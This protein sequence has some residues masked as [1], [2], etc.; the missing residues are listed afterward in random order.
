MAAFHRYWHGC[1]RMAQPIE[2]VPICEAR[3][4]SSSACMGHLERITPPSVNIILAAGYYHNCPARVS[5]I[6][7]GSPQ[8][9]AKRAQFVLQDNARPRTGGCCSWPGT[10]IQSDAARRRPIRYTPH[11][12]TATR[13]RTGGGGGDLPR[14]SPRSRRRR[15]PC[16][17]RNWGKRRAKATPCCT[18]GRNA[19]AWASWRRAPGGCPSGNSIAYA[20]VRP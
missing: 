15:G 1:A 17:S 10:S 13:E 11:R 20:W 2:D 5:G 9:G 14:P 7:S 8:Q 3:G 4:H 18:A 6:L 12:A 16:S 19:T